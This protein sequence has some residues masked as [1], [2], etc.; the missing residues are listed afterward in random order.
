MASKLRRKV[1][2]KDGIL[3]GADPNEYIIKRSN[4]LLNKRGY[5]DNDRRSINE[6]RKV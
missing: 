4:S 5:V 1:S 3:Y 6:N 2:N